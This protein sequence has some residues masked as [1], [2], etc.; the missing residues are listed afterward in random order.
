MDR[1]RAL[2]G[3][4]R[5]RAGGGRVGRVKGAVG[6]QPRPARTTC[7]TLQ[8]RSTDGT[9]SSESAAQK[10]V[11]EIKAAGG[12][13]VANYDSVATPEG[14]EA[15]VQTALDAINTRIRRAIQL[16][17]RGSREVLTLIYQRGQTQAQLVQAEIA[18]F[19]ASGAFPERIARVLE[20]A[21]D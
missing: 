4:R 15:I 6:C 5:E 9:G 1:P 21:G 14:G 2:G 11:D 19:Q 10:V 3:R 17:G 7:T 20:R 12:E 13:A 16:F 8:C 18:Q